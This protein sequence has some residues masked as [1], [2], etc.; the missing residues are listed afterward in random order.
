M[1]HLK[2]TGGLSD[3][4]MTV[5]GPQT[6][7]RLEAHALNKLRASPA[8]VEAND[9][10]ALVREVKRLRALLIVKDNTDA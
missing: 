3:Y 7:D 10:L 2:T 1:K 6:L 9:K 5:D 4:I 8:D